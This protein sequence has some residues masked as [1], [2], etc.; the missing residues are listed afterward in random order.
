MIIRFSARKLATVKPEFGTLEGSSVVI[1]AE[2]TTR[3]M[4]DI[5]RTIAAVLPADIW[6]RT[7]EQID[8]EE[9]MI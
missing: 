1:G 6:Q 3:D 9:R 2:M 4:T 5:I 7:V 8:N